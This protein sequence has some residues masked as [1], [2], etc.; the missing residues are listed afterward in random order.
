M[1][2]KIALYQ[3]YP[4]PFNP[5]TSIRF[6]IPNDAHVKIILYDIYGRKVNTLL[7]D[8]RKSGYHDIM[9]S[10]NELASGIYYYQF[11]VSGV[12]NYNEIKKMVLI[13]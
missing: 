11:I 7:D 2:A 5:S 1:P 3:N 4:N 6:A 13:K 9:V 12:S 8:E 10:G